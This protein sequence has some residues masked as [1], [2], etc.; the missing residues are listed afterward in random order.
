MGEEKTTS[1]EPDHAGILAAAAETIAGDNKL[2]GTLLKIILSP[3]GLIAALCGIAYLWWKN[4]TYKSKISD[5]EKE[6]QVCK[7]TIKELEREVKAFEK[8]K[9]AAPSPP[10]E[11]SNQ[12]E[13]IYETGQRINHVSRP[14]RELPR[15][16][17]IDLE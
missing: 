10:V 16:I 15:N 17:K 11:C 4:S 6:I 12:E 14:S 7:F 8:K 13:A 1:G 2:L 3:L 5:L 9:A